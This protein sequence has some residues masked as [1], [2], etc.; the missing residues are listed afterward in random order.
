MNNYL[1]TLFPFTALIAL[2]V[3]VWNRLAPPE[4]VFAKAW[5]LLALF[6]VATALLHYGAIVSGNKGGQQF[7]R[8]FLA[9]T[10]LKLF[11]FLLIIIVY[12][13]MKPPDAIHF[14]VCFL[15][16]Y[17]VFTVFETLSLLKHFKKK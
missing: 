3:F 5:F 13:M 10:V 15:V 11:V 12:V 4:Y 14:A 7:I 9:A 1:K 6:L 17:L 2:V 8:Y 16:L